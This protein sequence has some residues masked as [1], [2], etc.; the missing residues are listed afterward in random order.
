M[1]TITFMY[2]R[3]A[4]IVAYS[5]VKIYRYIVDDMMVMFCVF[6][7]VKWNALHCAA[8]GG[9]VNVVNWLC[10][11]YPNMITQIDTVCKHKIQNI[12]NKMLQ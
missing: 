3:V 11:R 4:R 10:H 7:Q 2:Y 9:H 5:H 8:F 1:I 12:C 6:S